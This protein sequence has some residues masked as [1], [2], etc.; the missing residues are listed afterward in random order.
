MKKQV[1]GHT[2]KKAPA[3][4]TTYFEVVK[5]HITGTPENADFT[6]IF[7]AMKCYNAGREVTAYVERNGYAIRKG[8]S[9]RTKC[10]PGKNCGMSPNISK[11]YIATFN[12]KAQP[13]TQILLD[14]IIR[15]DATASLEPWKELITF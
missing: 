8:I 10:D 14:H 4:R 7:K 15:I 6:D 9:E 3:N 11:R 12:R 13:L 5:Y 1:E 2:S